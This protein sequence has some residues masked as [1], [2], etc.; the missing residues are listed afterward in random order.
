[1]ERQQNPR[2]SNVYTYAFTKNAERCLVV[3]LLSEHNEVYKVRN[4]CRE[5]GIPY[6]RFYYDHDG[7]W[8]TR[9]YVIERMRKAL[10][11]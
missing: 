8:N 5:Q 10:G 1:M 4:D 2:A 7:W 9:A 6:L 3:E 11:R